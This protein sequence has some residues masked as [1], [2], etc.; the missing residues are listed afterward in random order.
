MSDRIL[1]LRRDSGHIPS[2]RQL[3]RTPP[4][5]E[6]KRHLDFSREDL[7]EASETVHVGLDSLLLKFNLVCARKNKQKTT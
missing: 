3:A 7:E 5:P 1:E 2:G 6:V 4:L